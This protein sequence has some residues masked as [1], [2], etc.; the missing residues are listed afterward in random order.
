MIG[1]IRN[2]ISEMRSA[3][4]KIDHESSAQAPTGHRPAG[5]RQPPRA[6]RFGGLVV[7]GCGHVLDLFYPQ[8]YPI[9][10]LAAQIT[11]HHVWMTKPR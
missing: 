10:C 2:E 5:R 7:P 6:D 11:S 8:F 4:L 3:E 9:V 1:M